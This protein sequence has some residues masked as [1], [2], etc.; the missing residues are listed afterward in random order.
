MCGTSH[1]ALDIAVVSF[2]CAN[3]AWSFDVL[4][5]SSVNLTSA[6]KTSLSDAN[7]LSAE[8]YVLLDRDF[9]RFCA[10]SVNALLAETKSKVDFISSHGV[11]VFHQPNQG[12]TTQIGSGGI[13]ASLTGL[14]VVSD[15]RIQ[16]VTKGGQGAPLVPFADSLLFSDY[17]ATLNLGGFAN[18]SI[19]NS[20]GII[21]YDVCPCNKALNHIFSTINS[22]QEFDE[23]GNLSR[24]GSIDETLLKTLNAISFYQSDP[25]KSLGHEWFVSQ[26]L[27]K[28][29][30]KD[31]VVNMLATTTEHIAEQ[32]AMN[33]PND[34]QVLIT[35]G[36]AFNGYLIERIIAKSECSCIIPEAVTIELKEAIEFAFLG[37]LRILELPNIDKN[38]TGAYSN[39][40]A[41]ALYLP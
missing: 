28:I 21:G 27:P 11:T 12:V 8:K 34:G 9:A 10:K 16:D 14:P 4:D 31:N 25:P 19:L 32:I 41:G 37:A 39:S 23:N 24:T 38:V 36:G 20:T 15:F 35:G 22:E 13:I 26:F 29:N 17:T 40:I 7:N 33:L 6:L 30:R 1:D 18:I 2:S 5:T 3:E